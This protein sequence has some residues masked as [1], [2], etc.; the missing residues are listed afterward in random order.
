MSV[1]NPHRAYEVDPLGSTSC[2]FPRAPFRHDYEALIDRY[3]STPTGVRD[4][5]ER[6][7]MRP[8]PYRPTVEIADKPEQLRHHAME[9]VAPNTEK[10]EWLYENLSDVASRSLLLQVLAYRSLGWRY[11]RLPLDNDE[12]WSAIEKLSGLAKNPGVPNSLLEM[13]LQSFNL[14]SIDRDVVV[15]TEPF[16]V[17]NEFLYSQYQY[18]GMCRTIGPELGDFALDCG[19]CYGGTTLNFADM[20][21]PRGRVYSFEFMPANTR[22]FRHNV[23]EN[24]NLQNRISLIENAVWS[25]SNVPMSIS[26]SGPATQ[27]HLGDVAGGQKV[28]SITIDDFVAKAGL[29]RVNFIKMDIEGAEIEA[30]KGAMLTIERN[31]PKL[32]ICV[33]HNLHDFYEVPRLLK[34]IHRDYLIYFGHSTPHGDE[35]V[36]FAI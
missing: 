34:G 1:R 27:V 16:G 12:F 2:G 33:Y 18:R 13:G 32:A 20:V 31:R 9:M 19:A 5:R 36:V 24:V 17:F 3:L 15:Y 26:G 4:P 28:Q 11:V 7:R 14:R 35:S 6:V 23:H 8:E 22:V 10:W 29:P 21:G 25:Q 30:L